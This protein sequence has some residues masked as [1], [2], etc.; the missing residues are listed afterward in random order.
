M[1]DAIALPEVTRFVVRLPSTQ[2]VE[3][4]ELRRQ[5]CESFPGRTFSIERSQDLA[6]QRITLLPVM[7]DATGRAHIC[8]QPERSLLIKIYEALNEIVYNNTKIA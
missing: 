2:T 5:L 3:P 6:Q 1:T 7:E 4:Q 8:R